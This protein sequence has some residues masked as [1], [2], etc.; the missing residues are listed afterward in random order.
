M[1]ALVKDLPKA[2]IV[3]AVVDPGVGTDRHALWVEV[4]GRHFIGPDNGLFARIVNQATQVKAH[5]I[6]YDKTKVSA[7]F[8]GRDVFAPF[9]AK[10]EIGKQAIATPLEKNKLVGKDWPIELAEIIYIDH[11]GNAMTGLSACLVPTESNLQ[12]GDQQLDFARNYSESDE[13]K[14]FWY[15][16]SFGLVELSQRQG[17]IAAELG[18]NIGNKIS[19]L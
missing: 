12:V 19:V 7:S 11:Y 16:N 6:K 3:L 15:K 8:H 10:L 9:A 14:M 4:D 17:S 13:N 1:Q 5:V 2:A 18:L